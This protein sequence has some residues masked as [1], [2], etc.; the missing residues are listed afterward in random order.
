LSRPLADG[1]L[2]N[3]VDLEVEVGGRCEPDAS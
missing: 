1:K 2:R 3:G